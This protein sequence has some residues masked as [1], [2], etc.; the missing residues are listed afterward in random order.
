MTDVRDSKRTFYRENAASA[1]RR[2]VKTVSFEGL[3][4]QAVLST[5]LAGSNNDLDYEAQAYGA[6]GN[7]VSIEYVAPE[8]ASD[9]LAVEV[10]GNAITVHLAG[11]GGT[12]EVQ[13]LTVKAAGGSYVLG[14]KDQYTQPIDYNASS[15]T[16]QAKLRALN[17]I[18][19]NVTVTGSAGGPYTITFNGSLAGTNVASLSVDDNRLLPHRVSAVVRTT[20]PGDDSPATNEVQT[21]GLV[22]AQVGTFTVTFDGQTT[23]ALAYNCTANQLRDA[24]RALS[25]VGDSDLSVTGSGGKFVVT[26]TGTL[27]ATNVAQ[28]TVNVAGLKASAAI[29]VATP[30]VG[31]AIGSTAA[32]VK[33]AIEADDDASVLVNVA[34]KSANDGSGLVT[35]MTKTY[36]AGGKNGLGSVPD[37]ASYTTSLTGNNNDMV[38]TAVEAGQDGNGIQVQYVDPGGATA[39]LGVVVDVEERIITVNLGRAA[40]AINSTAANVKTA[41][42]ANTDAA[43]LVTVANAGGN[44]G[45]GLVTALALSE[46]TGGGGQGDANGI[47]VFE[48]HGDVNVAAN[49]QCS[50]DVAGASGTLKLGTSVDDD[51]L[52]PSIVGT[53][54]DNGRTVDKT[55]LVAVGTAPYQTPHQL[56]NDGQK[57]YL[58][59]GTADLTDGTV[60]VVAYYQP[61]SEGAQLHPVS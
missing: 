13:T 31:F 49:L 36:L 14:F 27:A 33:T 23:S 25:N 3:S 26:F 44:D 28:M 37:S 38:F 61:V 30:G 59:P 24:L 58:K 4:A 52:I 1:V 2:V 9:A 39:T 12:N 8:A 57:V 22:N 43:A 10:E 29:T 51:C 5:N 20:T 45:S 17:T 46:L 19:D 18:G 35:A 40:S 53:T 32:Q 56:I 55:G 6:D 7:D 16:V 34:N 21:I 48:A 11:D 60:T 41:I 15:A 50:E 54:I 42:D 47:A